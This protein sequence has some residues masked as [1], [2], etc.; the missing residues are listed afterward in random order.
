MIGMVSQAGSFQCCKK[1]F[2]L[3]RNGHLASNGF[4]GYMI[5]SELNS[6]E[7]NTMADYP[8]TAKGGCH[9]GAIRYEVT[10]EPDDVGACHCASCRKTTG[11]PVVVFSVYLEKDVTFTK[12]SRKVYESSSGVHRTF[13]GDCGTP[14]S[15][16][17]EW[18]GDA[19]IGFYVST[20]DE[21][22]LF[23]P[24]NHVFHGDKISW[25]DVA[26]K[27]PRFLGMPGEG[28]EPDSFGPSK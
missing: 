17:S 25:F 2:K 23:P 13:C 6:E 20:L 9:C 21:P 15:Y 10:K 24:K 7:H 1:L 14:L 11:A 28:K 16:E 5:V 27:L 3:T 18:L 22:D 19:V 12:G 4:C 26:D 8:S